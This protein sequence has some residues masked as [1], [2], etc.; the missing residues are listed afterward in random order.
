MYANTQVFLDKLTAP[1]ASLRRVSGVD[2]RD[3]ATSLYR[4][5]AQQRLERTESSI[6]CR[7]GQVKVVRHKRQV[8]LFEGN[9][10]VGIHQ[11]EGEFMPEVAAL[12]GNVLMQ[13]G[14]NQPF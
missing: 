7:Q 10:P 1:A 14:D 5:V 12:V 11:P 9:Q 6:V 3:V 8:E 2:K 4:F 13:L